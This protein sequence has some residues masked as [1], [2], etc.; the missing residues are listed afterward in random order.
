MGNVVIDMSMSL[1]GYIAA[2]NDNPEQGLGEDGMRLH[3]W[4]FDDPSVFERVFGNLIEETGAVDELR[5]QQ[6]LCQ[7]DAAVNADVATGLGLE[8]AYQSSTGPATASELCHPFDSGVDVTTYFRTL[9]MK[10]A[11]GWPSTF[12]QYLDHSS[13]MLRPS[14]DCILRGSDPLFVVVHH[15]VEFR[16]LAG[17]R[18]GEVPARMIDRTVEGHQGVEDDLAHSS[19]NR[20]AEAQKLIGWP[21][22]PATRSFFETEAAPG[23]LRAADDARRYRTRAGDPQA[24]SSP[25]DARPAGRRQRG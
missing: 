3:N 21:V 12:G 2:P 9:L 14:N 7:L 6:R 22:R 16:R 15:R 13:Y 20:P 19:S 10:S 18:P 25:P 17:P 23:T 5:R 11:N 4:A 8:V 24:T 1:D